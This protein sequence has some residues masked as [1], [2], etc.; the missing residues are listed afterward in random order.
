MRDLFGFGLGVV[1]ACIALIIAPYSWQWWLLLSGGALMIGASIVDFFVRLVRR[2]PSLKLQC[3]FDQNDI[4]GCVCPNTILRLS[5]PQQSTSST[6]ATNAITIANWG[7]ENMGSI[8]PT[9]FVFHYEEPPPSRRVTYY[10]VKV[11]AANGTA[12]S[13]KGKL[14]SLKREKRLIAEEIWLPFAPARDDDALNKTI[15]EDTS[16]HLDFMF[17]SDSNHVEL[18]PPG[19][20]GPSAVDWLN[21]F[22][23]PGDYVLDIKILSP[24]AQGNITIL[25]HWTGER[26]TSKIVGMN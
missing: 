25:F 14:V 8:T 13:C 3:L 6:S 15:H 26:K 16:E 1:M 20:T 10:R 12:P 24:A 4:G 5:G 2:P 21:L 19:F 18:T 11:T 7:I 9:T 23:D 17:I 22:N